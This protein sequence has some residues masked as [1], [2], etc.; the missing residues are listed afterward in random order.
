MSDPY[1]AVVATPLHDLLLGIRLEQG[2]LCSIDF[3]RG[4]WALQSARHHIA[5]EVAQQLARYFADPRWVFDL[6]LAAIGTPFQQRVWQ[7]LRGLRAGWPVTYGALARELGSSARAVGG[8][9]RANPIPIVIPCHRVVSATGLGGFMG[10]TFGSETALKQW[11]LEHE[12][13]AA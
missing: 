3:L 8:A 5:R 2:R 1:D 7:T 9:C 6:P 11:L 10:R 12:R 4:E 13:G